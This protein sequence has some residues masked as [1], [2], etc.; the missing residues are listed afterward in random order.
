MDSGS[1][2]R[3]SRSFGGALFA[4]RASRPTI[5]GM[6]LL[7]AAA[8]FAAVLSFAPAARTATVPRIDL[9]LLVIGTAST[10]PDFQAWQSALQREG[11]PFDA[12]IESSA[13]ASGSGHT[14]IGVTSCTGSDPCQSLSGTAS[15]GT[16]EAKYEGV[17]VAT[18][19]L[20]LCSSTCTSALSSSDWAALE[21][22]EQT[23]QVRQITGD[24]Y[25]GG[26]GL[27][28]TNYGLNGPSSAGALDGQ[29]RSLTT[30]G[31]ADFPYLNGPGTMDTGT[32]GY[33]AT[34]LSPAAAGTSFDTLVTGP[35][36]SS[37][38]GIYTDA[39]G[40]QQ[41]V[42]TYDQNPYQLQEELVRPRR[43][44]VGHPRRVS[45]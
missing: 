12:L 37:L 41:L 36:N 23:Y 45:G 11:I 6:V 9:K 20:P 5:A 40:V 25:P 16:P 4:I 21:S 33:Q 2:R 42:E 10:E 29:A 38:V 34:P 13:G 39:N 30:S 14:S 15:D 8:L 24:A 28:M 35:N 19:G 17:I 44:R 27:G 43:A 7:A 3:R 32:Y 31:K 1:N 18:G 22:Y 26:G